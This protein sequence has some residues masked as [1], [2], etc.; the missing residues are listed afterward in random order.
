MIIHI[1]NLKVNI[2]NIYDYP[3]RF[4]KFIALEDKNY[5]TDDQNYLVGIPN[6]F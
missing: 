6:H 5:L 4:N 2:K 3:S 1:P